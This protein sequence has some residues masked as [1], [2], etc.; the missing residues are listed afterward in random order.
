MLICFLITFG[1]L[2]LMLMGYF[3]FRP[4]RHDTQINIDFDAKKIAEGKRRF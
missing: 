2:A 1:V 4:K 3:F